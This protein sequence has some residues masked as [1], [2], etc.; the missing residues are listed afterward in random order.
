MRSF[1]NQLLKL[2][3]ERNLTVAALGKLI[4]SHPS[5]ITRLEKG[6]RFPPR[7]EELQRLATAMGLS[8]PELLA[9]QRAAIWT[10]AVMRVQDLGFEPAEALLYKAASNMFDKKSLA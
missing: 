7:I 1:G 5:H 6:Q 3:K 4:G 10:V 2:R 9:L 8:E